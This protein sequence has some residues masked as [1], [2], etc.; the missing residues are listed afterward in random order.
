M[1]LSPYSKGIALVAIASVAWGAM[2]VAVQYLL[3]THSV[4]PGQ[5]SAFRLLTSGLVITAFAC[6]ANIKGIYAPFKQK[7]IGFQV[8]VNGIIMCFA[9]LTFFLSIYYSN[10]GTGTIFLATQPLIASI[11]LC[12]VKRQFPSRKIL[13]C[14]LLAFA[15][16]VLIVTDGN[17][18]TL[19]FSPKC[20]LWGTCSAI[21]ATSYTI[22]PKQVITAIGALPVLGWGL[23]IG[24]TLGCLIN[25]PGAFISSFN[26]PI[27]SAFAFIVIVG[28]IFPFWCYL[29]SLKFISP[30][31]VG[32]V[33]TLEPL[34]SFVF[35]I[36][37]LN[38][39]LG[40]FQT[41]G[42]AFII[43]T[44]FLLSLGG[45]NLSALK[46]SFNNGLARLK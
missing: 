25:P 46:R 28:T 7:K 24:G 8:L 38:E 14:M 42:I 36:I 44:V 21:L 22:Q 10:A 39:T 32:L 33:V 19:K 20:L 30:V 3:Q 27:F 15:G 45:I 29:T 5:L 43:G 6:L 37:L 17:L 41:I 26:L 4:H 9:H 11:Y 16:V 12:L 1:A 34:S 40:F 13:F 18:S 23:I 2:T 35:S 31:L